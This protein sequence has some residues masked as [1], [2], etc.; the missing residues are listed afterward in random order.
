MVPEHHKTRKSPIAH[1]QTPRN[2]CLHCFGI[3]SDKA[4]L[5][6]N[7]VNDSFLIAK[8]RSFRLPSFPSPS[9]SI[10]QIPKNSFLKMEP[11]ASVPEQAHQSGATTLENVPSEIKVMI[12]CHM[13]SL[14]SLSSIVHASPTYYQAY[15]I[16]REEILHNITLQT[17][18][19]N[20]IGLLDPWTAIHIP[21]LDR[22]SPHRTQMYTEYLERYAQGRMDSGRRRLAPRDSLAILSLH[23]NFT[24]LIDKYCKNVISLNPSTEAADDDPIPPSQSELHRL[25]RALW[26]Y[27][28][29]SQLFGPN[30]D[31]FCGD[32]SMTGNESVIGIE[33][34]NYADPRPA[35][36][37]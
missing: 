17:L 3:V 21:Q 19:R 32:F 16:A 13:P 18:Q 28:I 36:L 8:V 29:Y 35:K 26:R 15:L 24:V 37:R 10:A 25:Y 20:N 5:D 12:L 4:C 27:E 7:C 9:F 2:S 31:T 33:S 1:F 23:K 11:T 14:S 34:P 6:L 22:Y 30:K